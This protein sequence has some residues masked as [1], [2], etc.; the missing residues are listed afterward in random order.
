MPISRELSKNSL[1]NTL[2]VKAKGY[3]EYVGIAVHIFEDN[4]ILTLI[5]NFDYSRAV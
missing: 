2:E 1:K 5:H 3:Q 4:L